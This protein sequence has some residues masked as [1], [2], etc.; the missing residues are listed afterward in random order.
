MAKKK[1]GKKKANQ[2]KHLGIDFNDLNTR[3]I[4][5]FDTPGI[6]TSAGIRNPSDVQKRASYYKTFKDQSNYLSGPFLGIAC[7]V[8]VTN[9]SKEITGPMGAVQ[10]YNGPNYQTYRLRVWVPEMNANACLPTILPGQK[11]WKDS[12]FQKVNQLPLFVGEF[13]VYKGEMHVKPG[14][15]VT[16]DYYDTNRPQEGGKFLGV[17]F[18]TK[19]RWGAGVGSARRKHNEEKRKAIKEKIKKELGDEAWSTGITKTCPENGSPPPELL[20]KSALEKPWDAGSV[21]SEMFYGPGC[22]G[23]KSK[24]AGNNPTA[25][26]LY[27]HGIIAKGSTKGLTK[28]SSNTVEI[29]LPDWKAPGAQ[30]VFVK[31]K[32]AQ[33]P[34]K[35][36]VHRF[37]ELPLLMVFKQIELLYEMGDPAITN[38]QI[39]ATGGLYTKCKDSGDWGGKAAGG[40]CKKKLKDSEGKDTGKYEVLDWPGGYSNH[41]W[42]FA[43]DLNA[44]NNPLIPHPLIMP[45]FQDAGPDDILFTKDDKMEGGNENGK[46]FYKWKYNSENDPRRIPDKVIQIFKYYGFLWGGNY[47][48]K[49]DLHHFDFVADW[50]IM[51]TSYIKGVLYS[52]ENQTAG[53]YTNL[54]PLFYKKLIIGGKDKEWNKQLLQ[55]AKD[56]GHTNVAAPYVGFSLDPE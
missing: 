19:R 24:P 26:W 53:E 12:G 25:E 29:L 30:E 9:A 5:P 27:D 3:Q 2:K 38:F 37:V 28:R 15:V 21:A 45:Q 40:K 42:G 20:T 34:R 52:Y 11:G 18:D 35:I 44:P 46:R 33:H 48:N 36:L 17:A 32:K 54:E 49:K 14:D 1:K 39:I 56:K 50:E 22:Y 51:Y 55:I 47:G 4:S 23:K 16:V 6:G 41:S 8:S 7:S 10:G 43:L 31:L 13:V